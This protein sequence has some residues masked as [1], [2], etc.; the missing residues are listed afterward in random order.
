MRMEMS[1][2]IDVVEILLCMPIHQPKESKIITVILGPC[3]M[4]SSPN[5]CKIFHY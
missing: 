2:K 1:S 5:N 4:K 3:G